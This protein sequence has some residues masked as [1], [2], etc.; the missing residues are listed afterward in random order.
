MSVSA[1]DKMQKNA[2]QKMRVC[3]ERNAIWYTR[4]CLP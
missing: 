1:S 3:A 4:I 2:G